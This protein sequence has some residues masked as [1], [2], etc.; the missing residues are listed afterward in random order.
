[1]HMPSL[2]WTLGQRVLYNMVMKTIVADKVKRRNPVAKRTRSGGTSAHLIGSLR[3]KIRVTGDI[4]T[5]GRKWH[6]QS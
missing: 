3:D 6:A 5:T 1:M 4:M 2:F